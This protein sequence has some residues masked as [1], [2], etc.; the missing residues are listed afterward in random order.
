MLCS[1]NKINL[2]CFYPLKVVDFGCGD[3]QLLQ[4][5]RRVPSVECILEV[6]KIHFTHQ[7]VSP[8]SD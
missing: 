6:S 2:F 4:L 8:L 7:N 5:L 3:M 1:I